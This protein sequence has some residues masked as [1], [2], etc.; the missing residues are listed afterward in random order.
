MLSCGKGDS[1]LR[2]AQLIVFGREEELQ[3]EPGTQG[4]CAGVAK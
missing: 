2:L 1:I 3:A 4:G